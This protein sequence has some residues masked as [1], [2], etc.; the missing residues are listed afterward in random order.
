MHLIV[1][2]GCHSKLQILTLRRRLWFNVSHRIHEWI[3]ERTTFFLSHSLN[4]E[5][6]SDVSLEPLMAIQKCEA[7]S[8]WMKVDDNKETIPERSACSAVL[9]TI[10]EIFTVWEDLK[11][12]PS[13]SSVVFYCPSEYALCVLLSHV[14]FLPV[15]S[16]WT[17]LYTLCMYANQS[18]SLYDGLTWGQF[19]IWSCTLFVLKNPPFSGKENPAF[20]PCSKGEICWKIEI[21]SQLPCCPVIKSKGSR[22]VT[23]SWRKLPWDSYLT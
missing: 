15:M 16:L 23:L 7:I 12:P 18:G 3:Y 6:A 5:K 2:K 13:H 10:K 14:L 21:V 9:E 4:R 20:S 17:L 8:I 22:G 1:P 11:T 19:D